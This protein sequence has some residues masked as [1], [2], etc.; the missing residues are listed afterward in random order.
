MNVSGISNSRLGFSGIYGT[1][2]KINKDGTETPGFNIELKEDRVHININQS[3]L[4]KDAVLLEMFDKKLGNSGI[5][6][7][8]FKDL[9][10]KSIDGNSSVDNWGDAVVNIGK[11]AGS[12]KLG[13][14][15]LFGDKAKAN[16]DK[17]VG[18]NVKIKLFGDAEVKVK[19]KCDFNLESEKVGN[20]RII[21]EDLNI[22]G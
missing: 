19:G 21:G 2:T 3:N 15:G 17:I 20:A 12:S 8:R 13:L 16:I 11:M 1:A 18:K 10:I 14:F 6:L 5:L 22:K 4:A 7:G 9:K